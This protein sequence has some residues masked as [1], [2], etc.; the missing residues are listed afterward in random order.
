[1]Q[2]LQ[3]DPFLFGSRNNMN[4]AKWSLGGGRAVWEENREA[5]EA[6]QDMLVF[7]L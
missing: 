7:I 1:M 6:R 4:W 3:E 5:I 2:R